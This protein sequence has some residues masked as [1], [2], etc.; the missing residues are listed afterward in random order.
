MTMKLKIST[1]L[2]LLS[3]FVWTIPSFGQERNIIGGAVKT[4]VNDSLEF[5]NQFG[6]DILISNFSGIT[7]NGPDQEVKIK[8]VHKMNETDSSFSQNTK[9][10][11]DRLVSY[12]KTQKVFQKY[13]RFRVDIVR[14][15]FSAAAP[16]T[17]PQG[18]EK[19]VYF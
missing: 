1:L 8:I 15:G 7:S 5:N 2:I 18:V 3:C 13:H 16:K 14:Y 12:L 6:K 19:Y 10:L 11:S 4:F 9:A 17:V